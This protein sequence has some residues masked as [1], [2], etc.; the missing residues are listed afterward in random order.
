MQYKQ[1]V[2]I[3]RFSQTFHDKFRLAIRSEYNPWNIF[4]T[5]D[6]QMKTILLNQIS[7]LSELEKILMNIPKELK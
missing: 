3:C 2:K 1:I 4:S 6:E 7:E 5:Q